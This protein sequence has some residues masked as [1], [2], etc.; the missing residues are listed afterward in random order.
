MLTLMRSKPANSNNGYEA[1]LRKVRGVGLPA[2]P[3]RLDLSGCNLTALPPELWKLTTIKNL[4]LDH[5]QLNTLPPEI[6]QLGDLEFFHLRYNQLTALPPELWRLT[7]L[8]ILDL[9]TI[10]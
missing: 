1:A 2:R 9:R 6:D 7:K 4:N 8:K 5:N 10:G 3:T